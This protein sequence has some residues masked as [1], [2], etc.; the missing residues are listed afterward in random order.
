M[1]LTNSRVLWLAGAFAAAV[2]LIAIPGSTAQQPPA[3]PGRGGR[4]GPQNQTPNPADVQAMMAALPDKAPAKPGKPRK[5]LVLAKAAGFVHSSIP[6]AAATVEAL[7][8][9][10]GAWSTTISYDPAV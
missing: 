3:Q 4:G 1:T 7:G 9:K 10:T 2:Y 6:L 5:V 8:T